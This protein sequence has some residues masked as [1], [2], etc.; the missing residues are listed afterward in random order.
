[1]DGCSCLRSSSALHKL[2]P[3]IDS[4]SLSASAKAWPMANSRLC[5]AAKS[6]GK[7]CSDNFT[8]PGAIPF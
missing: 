5:K 8:L 2:I 6:I 4:P 7:S 3:I 1:M